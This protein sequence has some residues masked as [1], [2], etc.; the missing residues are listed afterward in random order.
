[1]FRENEIGS[2]EPGKQADLI[3]LDRDPFRI[4]VED[5]HKVRVLQTFVAG[6]VVYQAQPQ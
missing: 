5:L 2:L 3:V 6:D 4:D 1:M